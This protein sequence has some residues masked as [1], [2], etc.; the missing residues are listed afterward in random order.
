MDDAAVTVLVGL[1]MAVGL[2]GTILPALPGIGLIWLAA[3]AYG[4]M[5]GFGPVGWTALVVISVVGAAGSAAGFVLPSRAARGAGAS[6][7]SVLV[8]FVLAVIG[9]FV[10]PVIGF[11]LG[12]V[13]GIYAS[14]Y[15]RLSDTGAAWRA[16]WATL[17]GIGIAAAV[18]FAAGVAMVL[19]WAGWA[20]AG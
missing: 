6:R 3:V 12:G 16:T 17:K 4:I 13:V 2:A 20:I 9:F 5:T 18:Q 11:A 19:T 14:E 7:T 15:L 10:V 1:V 8:G